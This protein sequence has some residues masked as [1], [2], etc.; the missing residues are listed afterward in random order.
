MINRVV[1][2]GR[3][4]K[5]PLLSKTMSGIST[6]TFTLAVNRRNQVA[7]QPDADFIQCVTWRKTAENI[8]TY[9]HKGSLIGIEGRI[10]TRTYNNQQGQKVYVTEVVCDNVQFLEPKQNS[11][12][13]Q[14][15]QSQQTYPYEQPH[16]QTYYQQQSITA[17][18]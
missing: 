2:V 17:E 4:T 10:Q 18:A 5:D 14:Y 1:A 15:S 11:Q 7:G 8:T 9:L 12:P 3:L 6:C 16:V 13:S